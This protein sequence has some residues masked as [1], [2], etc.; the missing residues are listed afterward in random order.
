[1]SLATPLRHGSLTF[2]YRAAAESSRGDAGGAE[3]PAKA[4]AEWVEG[5]VQQ[6]SSAANLADA[7]VR[8]A[9]EL[10]AFEQAVIQ[11]TNKVDLLMTFLTCT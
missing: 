11:T 2:P 10:R 4:P 1:M 5:M 7:R 6:M 8:A 3:A 9:N